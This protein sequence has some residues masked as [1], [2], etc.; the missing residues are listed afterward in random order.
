MNEINMYPSNFK[1]LINEKEL[2]ALEVR[3]DIIEGK[4]RLTIIQIKTKE[5]DRE[6][7]IMQ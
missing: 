7:K 2:D 4:N 1:I 6:W 3:I 5:E